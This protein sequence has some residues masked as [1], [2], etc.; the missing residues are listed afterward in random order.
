MRI[1]IFLSLIGCALA[2]FIS[3][4]VL[5]SLSVSDLPVPITYL[6]LAFMLGAFALLLTTGLLATV[7]HAMASLRDF[8]SARQRSLRRLW[9]VQAK[10]DQL[11]QL[12]YFK[13]VQLN[14]FNDLAR[15]RLLVANNRKHI[16]G[17]ARTIAAELWSVKPQLSK[18]AF[19]QLQQEHRHYR[20]RLDG[21]GL[22]KLQQK[23]AAS[24][25]L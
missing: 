10:Q 11:K 2:L 8:F 16:N 7:K 9:F 1:K 24:T 20:S 18:A 14:Y 4:D 3:A 6:A 13:T 22:L 23:I 19:R 5:L 21:E 17:L 15:K 12:F 25:K